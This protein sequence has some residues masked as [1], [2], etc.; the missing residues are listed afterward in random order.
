MQSI[1]FLETWILK[2]YSE[3]SEFDQVLRKLNM[4]HSFS[5][6]VYLSGDTSK[7]VLSEHSETVFYLKLIIWLFSSTLTGVFAEDLEWTLEPVEPV[8]PGEESSVSLDSTVTFRDGNRE[9]VGSGLWR[10]GLFGSRNR[11]GSGERFNYKRKTLDRPQASTTLI[12]DSPL[13]I[14][15]AITDFEI[16]TVGCNDFNY[17]CLEFTGGDNPNPDYFFRVIDAMDNSAEANTL[18]KCKEQE[19]LSSKSLTLISELSSA[20]DV[21]LFFNVHPLLGNHM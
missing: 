2:N 7:E 5:S 13:E 12:A 10:Q 11:D 9:L 1:N 18:V 14:Q 16:G 15:D 3:F 19:C 20:Q 8:F 4:E 17:L 6:V 21:R